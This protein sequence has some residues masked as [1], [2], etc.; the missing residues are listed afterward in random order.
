MLTRRDL[1][2]SIFLVG[3]ETISRGIAVVLIIII[4]RQMGVIQFGLY[5][6]AISFVFL[7]SVFIE[8]GL[9]TYV[10]REISLNPQLTSQYIITALSIQ[11]ALSIAFGLIAYAT[12][13]TL[14]YS[15]DTR[16]AIG[17]FWIWMV[18]ISLGRMIR[19]VFKAQQRMEIEAAIN[20]FE[21]GVRFILVL[22]A[23]Y[24]G[25]GVLGIAV[26][27]IISAMLMLILSAIIASN[28][29]MHF[30]ITWDMHLAISLAKAA[31]PF[32]VSIICSVIM[33]RSSIVI[34]SVIKGNF[35]VGIFG[36]S[37]R[38]TMA[39]FF[40]PALICQVFF[41]KMSQYAVNN[42]EQYGKIVILLIR[43][44][45][46]LVYPLLMLIFILAPQIIGTIYTEEFLSTIPVL[47]ILVWVNLLN[48]GSYIGI[49]A[50]NAI[51]HEK[52]V[53]QIL[54]LALTIKFILSTVLTLLSGFIGTAVA[55][56]AS[57]VIV[58]LL[59]FN[60]LYHKIEVDLLRQTLLQISV[61]ITVSFL[62]ISL[63]F[64]ANLNSLVTIILFISI[65]VT[66]IGFLKF[67]TFHDLTKLK[68]LII[69][70]PNSFTTNN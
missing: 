13:L 55:T 24:L 28:K 61:I 66:T 37:F 44:V 46:L 6:T 1:K 12:T 8:I 68:Q 11:T 25:Y 49:Y 40:I 67:V 15:S 57:E 17:F 64:Y 30:S 5:S 18:F 42:N 16:T 21:N 41:S 39:L 29:Y 52:K 50:L 36:A 60:Y 19:V 2:N 3:A 53:M 31:F 51:G 54:M 7:F 58:T 45:F 63:G 22:I 33:Y 10:F 35:E 65:F 32:A 69:P 70:K 34:L 26:A 43:Y 48:A 62:T 27:S 59:L 20:I 23:L 4:A 56:L 14:N 47:R 9:S 38:L